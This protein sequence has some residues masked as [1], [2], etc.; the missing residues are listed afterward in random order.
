MEV[1]HIYAWKRMSIKLSFVFMYRNTVIKYKYI[2]LRLR[3]N[4]SLLIF[5]LNNLFYYCYIVNP[6]YITQ[7]TYLMYVFKI[8]KAKKREIIFVC[9]RSK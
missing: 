6:K 9:P 3:N 8:I 5:F 7:N 1:V 2:T 4:F